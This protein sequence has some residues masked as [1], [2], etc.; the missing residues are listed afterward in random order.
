MSAC[1]VVDFPEQANPANK[2][3]HSSDAAVFS[4]LAMLLAAA[5]SNSDLGEHT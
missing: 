1:I 2:K 3:N 4:S 5:M